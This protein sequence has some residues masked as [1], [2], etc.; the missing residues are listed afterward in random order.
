MLA[1]R[2]A[3][4]AYNLELN[5]LQVHGLDAQVWQREAQLAAVNDRSYC[6]I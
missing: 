4:A 2:L 6:H 5:A 3:L 1:P